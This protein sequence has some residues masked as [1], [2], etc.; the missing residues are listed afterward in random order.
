MHTAHPNKPQEEG[1]RHNMLLV[2]GKSIFLSHLPMFM[3]PHNRQFILEAGF[4]N[5]ANG[6][7]EIYFKDRQKHPNTR[8]YTL[9]PEVLDL[10][11]LLAPGF[12]VSMPRSFNGTAFR[13]HLERGGVSIGALTDIQVNVKRIIYS[14]QFGPGLSKSDHLEYVLFGKDQE[15][16]LAHVIAA[17]PDFDQI[18]SV[19]IDDPP[20]P[21]E[22]ARG[23]RVSLLDRRN[24]ASERIKEGERV[25][26]QGHAGGAHQFLD[27]QIQAGV[28]FY[29]EEGDLSSQM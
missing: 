24:A 28:E 5:G 21:D 19:K 2:G 13:G 20:T 26:A 1:P 23:V 8:I 10:E 17:P 7:D 3:V 18:I 14:Q 29:I 27:L 22:F 16:F 15:F 12:D 9:Q 25:Q 11:Q 4:R 6:V